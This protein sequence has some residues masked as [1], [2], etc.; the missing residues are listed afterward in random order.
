MG[1]ST[2]RVAQQGS[3]GGIAIYG[4]DPL[5]QSAYRDFVENGIGMRNFV[6]ISIPGLTKKFMSPLTVKF[7]GELLDCIAEM[8]KENNITR[9][10]CIVKKSEIDHP[11]IKHLVTVPQGSSLA[12]HVMTMAKAFIKK[13]TGMDVEL[14]LADVKEDGTIE[15]FKVD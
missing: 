11:L 5:M 2:Y 10:A 4:A 8:A 3:V 6:P 14:Y 13:K 15:F 7:A 9:V 12:A 1:T